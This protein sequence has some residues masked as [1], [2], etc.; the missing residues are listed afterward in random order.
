MLALQA[1]PIGSARV[2]LS[3]G[4]QPCCRVKPP[5]EDARHCRWQRVAL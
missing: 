2:W 5:R 1:R 3:G 4:H